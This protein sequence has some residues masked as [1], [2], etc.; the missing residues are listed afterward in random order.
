MKLDEG[1]SL[2]GGSSIAEESLA[3]KSASRF[4]QATE[5]SN[6][7]DRKS[8]IDSIKL[9]M[10]TED[11]ILLAPDV[12]KDFAK[13]GFDKK[14]DLRPANPTEQIKSGKRSQS[15]TINKYFERISRK[16]SDDEITNKN[17][18]RHRVSSKENT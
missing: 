12:S 3:T 16:N 15:S 6:V 14:V 9:S 8:S 2:L 4:S 18:I 5:T 1:R 10:D 13:S 11:N 7:Y 17:Q